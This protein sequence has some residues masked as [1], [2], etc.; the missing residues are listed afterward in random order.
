MSIS[1]STTKEEAQLI[2]KIADRADAMFK[3]AGA[4]GSRPKSSAGI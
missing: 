2:S 1:F 4:A 3:E